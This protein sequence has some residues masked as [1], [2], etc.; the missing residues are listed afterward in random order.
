[1]AHV[2]YHRPACVVV[3]QGESFRTM[4]SEVSAPPRSPKTSA[5]GTR[6]QISSASTTVPLTYRP[7]GAAGDILVAGVVDIRGSP[8]GIPSLPIGSLSSRILL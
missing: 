3:G 1:M 4:S 2:T 8:R 5:L 6:M 7:S